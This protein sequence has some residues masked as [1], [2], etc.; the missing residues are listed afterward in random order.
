MTNHHNNLNG[1]QLPPGETSKKSPQQV[2]SE[3][4][5]YI[6]AAVTLIFYLLLLTIAL[7]VGYVVLRVTVWAANTITKAIGL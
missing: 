4:A 5:A 1:L 2:A 3:I 6:K 7:G